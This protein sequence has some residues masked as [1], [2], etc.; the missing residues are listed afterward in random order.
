MLKEVCHW[1]EAVVQKFFYSFD[2]LVFGERRWAWSSITTGVVTL[3]AGAQAQAFRGTHVVRI[4]LV[5][6]IAEA[7]AND[8]RRISDG[9]KLLSLDGEMMGITWVCLEHS[10]DLNAKG[11]F[12][13]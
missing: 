13:T 11:F 3:A 12:M 8:I 6:N 4:G 10:G 5:A 2:I 9:N 1:G 7:Q